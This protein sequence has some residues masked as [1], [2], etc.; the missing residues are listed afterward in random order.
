MSRIFYNH[1]MVP[2][3][4]PNARLFWDTMPPVALLAA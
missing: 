2:V 4:R 1:Y 3:S